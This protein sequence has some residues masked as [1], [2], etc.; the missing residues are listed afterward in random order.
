M[1][2]ELA[3]DEADAE[4]YDMESLQRHGARPGPGHPDEDDEDDAAT[5]VGSRRGAPVADDNV[6]FEIGDEDAHASED[7]EDKSPR[8]R[9][10]D[11]ER[12]GLIGGQR[13][14]RDD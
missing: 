13:K 10:A 12:R 7:E 9:P 5:L 6:V 3:Q 8:P 14:N 11:G 4:D 2:E 1:S